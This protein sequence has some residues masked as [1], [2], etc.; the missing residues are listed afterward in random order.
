MNLTSAAI[1]EK[2]TLFFFCRRKV[3]G[4]PNDGGWAVDFHNNFE[5][6]A[7]NEEPA[8]HEIIEAA[9]TAAD[10]I[11]RVDDDD[12]LQELPSQDDRN[13]IQIDQRGNCYDHKNENFHAQQYAFPQGTPHCYAALFRPPLQ[14]QGMVQDVENVHYDVPRGESSA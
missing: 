8:I 1:S 14:G 7:F 4:V 12:N 6:P 2:V 3:N 13:A 11:P 10:P 9:D 5:N